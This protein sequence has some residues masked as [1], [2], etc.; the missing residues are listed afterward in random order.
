MM[1]KISYDNIVNPVETQNL[2]SLQTKQLSRIR[3]CNCNDLLLR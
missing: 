1:V 2:A 3:G